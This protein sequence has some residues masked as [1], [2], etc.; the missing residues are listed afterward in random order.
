MKVLAALN[1]SNGWGD[2]TQQLTNNE[3]TIVL[4]DDFSKFTYLAQSS[5]ICYAVSGLILLIIFEKS[6]RVK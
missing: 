1:T 3:T 2:I 6:L 4:P 5:A